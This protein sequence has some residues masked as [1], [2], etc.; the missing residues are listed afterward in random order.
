MSETKVIQEFE[1]YAQYIQ[2]DEYKAH[3]QIHNEEPRQL[4]EMQA[5]ALDLSKA[6]L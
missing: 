2:S 6:R 5:E 4:N 1:R 3:E